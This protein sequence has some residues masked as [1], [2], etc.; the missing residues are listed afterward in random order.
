M[1]GLV[2][3][4]SSAAALNLSSSSKREAFAVTLPLCCRRNISS[5]TSFASSIFPGGFTSRLEILLEQDSTADMYSESSWSL[6]SSFKDPS[7]SVEGQLCRPVKKEETLFAS[8]A[9]RILPKEAGP[10]E[11]DCLL[12]RQTSSSS[13]LLLSF[14]PPMAFKSS[15][16]LTNLEENCGRV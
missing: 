8:A 10:A 2:F 6:V 7:E 15:P 5:A 14:N 12:H 16:L 1:L 11:E 3:L 13:S 9:S 4:S